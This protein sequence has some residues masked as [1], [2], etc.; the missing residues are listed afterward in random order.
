MRRPWIKIE[1]ATPDKPEICVIANQ[2]KI[3][4]DMVVGKLV[5]FWAWLV[6]NQVNGSDLGVTLEFIDRL[7]SRKG[8]AAA[9]I[10]AGWLIEEE[11]VLSVPNF[12]RHNSD[13][14]K[15]RAL[16]A[17]RVARHRLGQGKL[18]KKNAKIVTK[19]EESDVSLPAE[20]QAISTR[21]EEPEV[22]EQP[23]PLDDQIMPQSDPFTS[24]ND[25][26]DVTLTSEG[27]V[28]EE[29]PS[30]NA[31]PTFDAL[32]SEGVVDKVSADLEPDAPAKPT[33][34]PKK[35]KE[36]IEDEQPLLL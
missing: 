36:V 13:L 31:L 16:T 5:R 9:L 14:A 23:S 21:F 12:D 29:V 1:V 28:F 32:H 33:A 30:I 27:E 34:S 35:K 15:T 18:P 17:K 4:E 10:R 25:H 11:G 24:D 7:V 22:V 8:F 2:L 26:D 6:Q 3:D 20:D 19:N